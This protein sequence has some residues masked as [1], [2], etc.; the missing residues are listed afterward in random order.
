MKNKNENIQ[1]Y[2]VYD[3]IYKYNKFTKGKD[4]P[5]VATVALVWHSD[6]IHNVARGIA[7]CSKSDQFSRAVGRKIAI[8]RARQAFYKN[9]S[10]LKIPFYNEDQMSYLRIYNNQM[11]YFL[12]C[13]KEQFQNDDECLNYLSESMSEPTEYE[14][15]L[16]NL[17]RYKK[18]IEMGEEHPQL[19]CNVKSET[20][21]NLN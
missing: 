12:R 13:F 14:I 15:F 20:K 19:I 17:N 10:S 2:Y 1:I 11:R 18:A 9:E 8:K 6:D 21:Y 5:P 7:V 16:M 4:L 3:G